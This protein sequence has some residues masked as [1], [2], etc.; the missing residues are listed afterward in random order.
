MNLFILFQ[1]ATRYSPDTNLGLLPKPA[2]RSFYRFGCQKRNPVIQ[3]F[4][5]VSMDATQL[6]VLNVPLPNWL[7]TFLSLRWQANYG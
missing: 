1:P 2:G 3:S 6:F 7:A 5:S 4:C